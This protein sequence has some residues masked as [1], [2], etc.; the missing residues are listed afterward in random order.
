MTREQEKEIVRVCG[1][2]YEEEDVP[3]IWRRNEP[4]GDGE[5]EDEYMEFEEKNVN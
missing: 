2:G 5:N 3:A 1:P 4:F